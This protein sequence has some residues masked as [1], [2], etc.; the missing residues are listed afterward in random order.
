MQELYWLYC[1]QEYKS[2]TH[3]QSSGF[4]Y[5]RQNEKLAFDWRVESASFRKLSRFDFHFR[6]PEHFIVFRVSGELECLVAIFNYS[7][8]FALT[9]ITP[10]SDQFY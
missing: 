1:R 7:E 10:R 5:E 2:K 4:V 3:A 6:L 8:S 9:F